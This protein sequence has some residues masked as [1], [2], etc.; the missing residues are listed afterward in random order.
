MINHDTLR[1]RKE[2]EREEKSQALLNFLSFVQQQQ[3][4]T[5]HHSPN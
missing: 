5:L 3:Q 2:R 4:Q 1:V